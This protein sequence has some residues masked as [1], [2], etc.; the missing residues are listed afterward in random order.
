MKPRFSYVFER[1][2]GALM[3]DELEEYHEVI[4]ALSEQIRTTSSGIAFHNRAL[5]YWEIGEA[6]KAL[7]DFDRAVTELP[8]DYLPAQ[9]RGML[10]QKMDRMTEALLS[11]DTAVS[12]NPDAPTARMCRGHMLM[13]V[14]RVE[15]ALT[16]F[17]HVRTIDP[18]SQPAQ[19]AVRDAKARLKEKVSDAKSKWWQVWRT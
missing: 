18:S 7:K 12:I 3:L 6:E 19:N 17:S 2:Y 9:I 14:G 15:E 16:D 13:S 4:E 5:A 1:T 8:K 10:L 11:L